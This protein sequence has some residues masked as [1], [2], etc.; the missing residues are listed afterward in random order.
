MTSPLTPKTHRASFALPDEATAR[1]VFD[2]LTESL[3]ESEAAVAA[4]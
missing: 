2:L 4:C 1:R 3:F